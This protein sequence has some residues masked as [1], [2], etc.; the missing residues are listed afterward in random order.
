MLNNTH[1]CASRTVDNE[2]RSASA[3]VVADM[4]AHK[5]EA[6]GNNYK[7][8]H[9]M[10]DM[11]KDFGIRLTYVQA[12]NAHELMITK[13]RGSLTESYN[14]LP[15]YLYMLKQSNTGT[16]V[17]FQT[18]S[19]GRFNTCFLALGACRRG[20]GFCRPILCINAAHLKT[21]FQG[22]LFVAVAVD[23]GDHIFPV[24]FGV[25]ET[26]CNDVSTLL[27]FIHL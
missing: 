13:I 6:L 8:A 17:D 15:S 26:E 14:V 23:A 5:L 24:A 25:G 16:Y 18:D 3:R 27:D 4:L 20:F 21:R 12:Y 10:E 7:P 2:N 11:H 22:Q 1:T 9:V 19:L